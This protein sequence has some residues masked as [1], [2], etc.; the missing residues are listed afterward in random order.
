VTTD[1]PTTLRVWI[2]HPAGR[3]ALGRIPDGV[4]VDAWEG[5]GDL[6]EGADEVRLYVPP[7]VPEGRSAAV[8]AELPSLEV[9]QA[10]TAGVGHVRP[11]VPEGV[12]LCSARGAHSPATSEWVLATTLASLRELPRYVA[13]QANG[14]ADRLPG[15]TLD[16]KTVLILGYGSIGQAVEK[17]LAGFQVEI[18]RV[19]S[20]AREGVH[21][22]SDVPELLARS[23]VLIVLVP[24]SEETAGLVSR[25]WL[26]AL[27]DGALVV[28]AARGGVVDQEALIDEV[29]SGRLRAAL[30]VADPDPLP[31][32]HPLRTAAGVLYT[33]HVAGFTRA[34]LPAVYA[35]VGRQIR[36]L[37][38]G[39]PLENVV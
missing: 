29:A 18:V 30:D 17:R 12:T 31:P 36:H 35:L 11:H 6:P 8:M 5:D 16:G 28:N 34:T 2:A 37:A 4:L 3:S 38:A 33:P 10:L 25:E 23:D 21:G 14:D 22:P 24:L 32:G 27:P 13:G 20:Q 39:E 7:F 26:G 19:A 1:S 9:V 15:D